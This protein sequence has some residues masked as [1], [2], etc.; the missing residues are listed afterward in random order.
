MRYDINI[1][2]VVTIDADDENDARAFGEELSRRIEA[3]AEYIG[4]LSEP[5]GFAIVQ[6]IKPR[7][8]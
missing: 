4:A 2:V 7:S 5:R 6:E 8:A 3:D 1:N